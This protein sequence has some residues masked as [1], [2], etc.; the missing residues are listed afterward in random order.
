MKLKILLVV[1]TILLIITVASLLYLTIAYYPKQI[2]GLRNEYQTADEA[3]ACNNETCA[4]YEK[5]LE[6]YT[7]RE[8]QKLHDFVNEENQKLYNSVLAIP[9]S[10]FKP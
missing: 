8:N 10:Q 6:E 4:S 2:Q 9:L 3:I 5:K 7:A 1:D